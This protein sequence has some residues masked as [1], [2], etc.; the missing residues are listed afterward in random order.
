M[1]GA[2]A[3]GVWSK[4]ESQL[5]INILELR[6]IRL[7]LGQ[8][9]THLKGTDVLIRTDN[10]TAK[11]FINRQG[12][13]RS[14]ALSREAS[15]LFAWAEDNLLSIT[16]EHLAGLENEEADWLSRQRLTESEWQLNPAVFQEIVTRF[17]PPVVDLFAS[18]ANTQLRRFYSRGRQ[19][20]AEAVDAL[21]SPW[22]PGLLY[23]FPPVAL[24]QRVIN[25]V[26]ALAAEVVLVAPRWPRRPWFPELLNLSTRPPWTLPIREDLLLQGPTRHP[27]PQMFQLTAW[28]LS[29]DC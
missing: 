27:D 26:R 1:T 3:Q 13:T 9:V 22:P 16:A 21:Q 24:I 14:K 20:G 6:A 28:R 12:G 15:L 10:V 23:A 8:F 11:A 18:S 17:G 29:G 19:E 2:L 4:K 25:R 5:H 7:S